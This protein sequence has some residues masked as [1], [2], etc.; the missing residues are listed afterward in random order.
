MQSNL[1]FDVGLHQG[2]DSEFYLKKGFSVVAVEADPR[3]AAQAADR[4]RTYLDKGQLTIVNKAIA[5]EEGPISFFVS[6]NVTVWGTTDPTWA[7][8]NRQ[9]GALIKE[10]SVEG[11]HF[12]RL[13]K[14]YGVPYYVKIDI[15]GADALC[16]EGLLKSDERPKFL[17]IESCKTSFD[18]LVREFCLLQQLG[19]KRYK[20]V[21]QH[22]IAEQQLP[23]PP[24]EGQFVE[25]KFEEGSSGAFGLE[26]PGEWLA[27]E[28]ALKTYMAIFRKYRLTGDAGLSSVRLMRGVLN[29]ENS[30]LLSP[31]ASMARNL[32]R[33]IGSRLNLRAGW[34]DT[35]AM[36]EE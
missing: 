5:N 33:N 34:Y 26:L 16:L 22:K 9:L 30:R 14:E 32:I 12:S 17:S 6:E 4:L 15:E 10:I 19:Y 1:I 27:L 23:N 35:H 18:Q 13:I 11:I 31:V 25:H 36:L 24:K 28:P 21:A 2:E 8:R 29:S 7:E 20:I 3:I